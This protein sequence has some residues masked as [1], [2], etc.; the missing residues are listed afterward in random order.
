MVIEILKLRGE[1]NIIGLIDSFKTKGDKVMEYEILGCE[2][3]I[4]ELMKTHNLHGGIIA[5]GDNWTRKKMRDKIITLTKKFKFISA[6]H[7]FSYLY[8]GIIIPVGVVVM[9][10][11]IVNT[12]AKIGDFC[13]LNTKASLGHDSEMKSFSSLAPGVTTGGNVVLGVESAVCIGATIV[14]NIS[15]GDYCV[16]GASSL[17][18]DDFKNNSLVYGTPA[19][20]VRHRNPDEKYLGKN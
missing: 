17:V 8:E 15:I 1:Y 7:P 14:N 10:G 2:E 13:I 9:A 6:I 19:R 5:I 4:P 3:I 20:L 11:V 16:I 18:I 12:D